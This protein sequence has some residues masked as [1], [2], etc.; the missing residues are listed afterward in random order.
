MEKGKLG[1][2]LSDQGTMAIGLRE[3]FSGM[4]KR[5]P[6]GHL[7]DSSAVPLG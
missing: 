4:M 1:V 2:L 3:A 7:R 6:A 5:W